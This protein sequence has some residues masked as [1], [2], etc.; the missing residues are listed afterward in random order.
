MPR[1]LI[2]SRRTFG[3]AP[4]SRSSRS[5]LRR[6]GLGYLSAAAT[7]TLPTPQ[8][9]CGKNCGSQTFLSFLQEA[10]STRFLPQPTQQNASTDCSGTPA[11]T[12]AAKTTQII[13]GAAAAGTSV[14]ASL[15]SAAV[16]GST[17][18]IIGTVIG[19]A[20]GALTAIFT[21]HAQAVQL[22]S[23]LICENVPAANQLLAQ[24]DSELSSGLATPSQASTAYDTILA[25]FTA[26]MKSDPSYK[27]GDA[28]WGYVQGLTVLVA[29]RKA[30]LAAGVLT[31]GQ[32]AP[33]A[34]GAGAASEQLSSSLGI[35]PAVLWVAIGL[36]AL[37]LLS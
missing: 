14:T 17:I 36:G 3:S 10:I 29:T 27:T 37:W 5:R 25:Q 26:A 22:Q 34:S 33:W 30:D 16:I 20:A 21:H 12:T 2:A 24:I 6:R 19:L 35:S 11:S 7:E 9:Y 15:A 32:A 4:L 18:P 13:S 23:N 31:D 28:L 1:Y 8:Q